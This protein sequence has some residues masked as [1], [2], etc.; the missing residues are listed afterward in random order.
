MLSFNSSSSFWFSPI[1]KLCQPP[2]L[3][4][5]LPYLASLFYKC[6]L[7]VYC[8]L[9]LYSGVKQPIEINYTKEYHPVTIYLTSFIDAIPL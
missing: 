5:I 2:S 6:I 4:K 3:L 9:F 8:Y 7:K 1:S